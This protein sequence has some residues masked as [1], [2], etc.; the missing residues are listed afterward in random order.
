MVQM[1]PVA[2]ND[3]PE[4]ETLLVSGD[5]KSPKKMKLIWDSKKG[6]D[7]CQVNHVKVY[8]PEAPEGYVCISDY[9]KKGND[10][11]KDEDLNKI[12]CVHYECVREKKSGTKFYDNKGVSYDKYDSYRKYV[13]KVHHMNLI[14]NFQPH[15]GQPE[16]IIWE[17]L[18][19]KKFIRIRN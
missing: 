3:G 5:V 19:S 8:R 1:A 6:C 7:D 13:K 15:F 17:Q 16:L 10:P 9:V 14:I 11:I 18:K 2:N 4:K 12:K